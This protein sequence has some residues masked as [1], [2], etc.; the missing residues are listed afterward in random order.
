[1]RVFS[2]DLGVCMRIGEQGS[3]FVRR[4]G[5]PRYTLPATLRLYRAGIRSRSWA[6]PKRPRVS[7]APGIPGFKGAI[8][9]L[10][11]TINAQD[12][13]VDREF[14]LDSFVPA[15]FLDYRLTRFS[16]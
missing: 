15:P 16:T 7:P 5:D 4:H 14:L 8:T 6:R 10:F 9:S 2:N 3:E 11:A 12:L 1:M 13:F